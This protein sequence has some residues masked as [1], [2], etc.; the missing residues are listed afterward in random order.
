MEHFYIFCQNST[1]QN[2]FWCWSFCSDRTFGSDVPSYSELHR[3]LFLFGKAFN[4]HC[5]QSNRKLNMDF[6]H[7]TLRCRHV[8]SNFACKYLLSTICFQLLLHEKSLKCIKTHHLLLKI[9][10]YFYWFLKQCGHLLIIAFFC[11]DRY[12]M[13]YTTKHN[14]N[15]VKRIT[16][17]SLKAFELVSFASLWSFIS[18]CNFLSFLWSC[19]AIY[20]Q[21]RNRKIHKICE[22]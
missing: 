8:L 13:V 18:F 16:I 5:F 12:K 19:L 6:D 4:F 20:K 21:K 2:T 17:I 22:K 3:L 10:K 15:I 1:E 9:G 7:C 11:I 14:V